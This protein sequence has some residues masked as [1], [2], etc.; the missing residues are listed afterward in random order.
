MESVVEA[1]RLPRS[2][3]QP[4]ALTALVVYLRPA[5]RAR[6]LTTLANLGIFVAEHQG[7]EGF[8]DIAVRIRADIGVLVCSERPEHVPV[9]GELLD[10]V[11]PAL[12]VS[13]PEGVS[14]RGFLDL[15][16]MAC[17]SDA[18]LGDPARL[19]Q[20]AQRAR[21][22]RTATRPPHDGV[23]FGDIQLHLN[24]PALRRGRRVVSLSQSEK[25]VLCRLVEGIGTAVAVSELQR[26]AAGAGHELHPGF[27]KA[28]VLRIRRKVEDLGG[29]PQHL[30]TVRG[31]GY[32]L[33]G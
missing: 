16:A 4:P 21:S 23:V 27:L 14:P 26:C 1:V 22:L 19:A 3:S 18:D 11:G 7:P 12:I 8:R 29:D 15:G 25:E 32:I 31:F 2:V 24:P 13:V 28:V 6:L 33:I 17:L 9:L 10:C 30:R 20:V 5:P